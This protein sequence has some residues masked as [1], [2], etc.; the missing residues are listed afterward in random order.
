MGVKRTSNFKNVTSAFDPERNIAKL[1]V[2]IREWG[3][4]H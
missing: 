3:I 2:N 1:A 4:V